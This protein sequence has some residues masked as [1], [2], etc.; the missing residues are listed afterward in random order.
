MAFPMAHGARL[1]GALGSAMLGLSVT[2]CAVAPADQAAAPPPAVASAPDAT[3]R[4]WATEPVPA[5]YEQVGGE[6]L[7]VPAKT[8]PD[9]T[10]LR[11]PV[12]RR[13]MVPRI[14][15]PRGEIRFETPCPAILT[16][17]FIASLQRALAARGFYVGAPTGRMDR[18]TRKAVG[19]YQA[20]Q[21]QDSEQLSVE[22]A[23]AL[24]L[25]AVPRTSLN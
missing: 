25:I 4:C 2:G 9:G 3:G 18:P 14:V 19:Q 12:Y 16:P 11:A 17:G 6:I 24:G 5:I 8:A 23:R 21:G 20:R 22:T 1:R 7:V 15:R 13:A 10:V